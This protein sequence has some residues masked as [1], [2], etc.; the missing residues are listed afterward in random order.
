M[1][2]IWLNVT[3]M[4]DF[5]R[6]PTVAIE[7]EGIE[8]VTSDGRRLLDGTSAAMVTSLGYSDE[9]VV[10]AMTDQLG[11]LPFWPVLHGTSDVALAL[12]EKLNEV[13]PG[14]LGHVFLLSGGSESTETAIKMARQYHFV[15][16]HPE[17]TKIIGRYGAYHGATMGALSASGLKSKTV[18]GPLVPDMLHVPPPDCRNCPVG[19]ECSAGC[20]LGCLRILE[21]VIAAEGRGSIAAVIVDPVMAA[22]GIIIPPPTYY[23]RVREIC[24]EDIL[25]IFDEVLTG[26]GRV[27][28][29]FAADHYGVVPDIIC[30][31]KGLSAGYAPLAAT[32]ARPFVAE[33]FDSAGAAFQHIHTYGGHPV[34]AAAGL[35]TIEQLQARDLVAASRRLGDRLGEGLRAVAAA[36]PEV[37]DVRCIGLLAGLELVDPE[38]GS[39]FAR[40]LAP[41]VVAHAAQHEELLVRSTRD[42][43]QIAPP[44][45]ST[46][47]DIDRI[48]ERL[49]RSLL[50]VLKA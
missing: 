24:G 30:L 18:F 40:P 33:A 48:L 3:Q 6:Q 26:F 10:A 37:G 13:L 36:V 19:H 29:W 11:R 28:E 12:T 17:R 34:A 8:V 47:D 49:E 27:G 9:A 5:R 23:Q 21:Q 2:E 7:G 43:V 50:A 4:A 31:G 42:V 44:L 32:V 39:R 1:G 20:D 15:S 38:T 25:L 14:D 45:I 46:E 41:R 35:A 22:A 16:G